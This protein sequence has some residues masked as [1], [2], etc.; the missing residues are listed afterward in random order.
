MTTLCVLLESLIFQKGSSPDAK[1]EMVKL[2][3]LMSTV[4]AF[5]YL[6]S[7]AGNLVEASQEVFDSF[8]RELF[9]DNNDIRVS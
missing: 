2:H 5:C 6:W 9:Q 8:L 1:M 3:P 4:F 7:I